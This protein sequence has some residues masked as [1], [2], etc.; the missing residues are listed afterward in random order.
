MPSLTHLCER[1]EYNLKTCGA[2]PPIDP[3]ENV[4]FACNK[5]QQH[6]A[7]EPKYLTEK[8]MSKPGKTY[9]TADSKNG[10]KIASAQ[11]P[12]RTG[13]IIP[14]K[15]VRDWNKRVEAKKLEKHKR[16]LEKQDA[17]RTDK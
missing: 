16:K 4:V 6:P 3:I 15:E 8:S 9:F 13:V 5:F 2:D 17:S 1:C 11:A 14:D 10:R 12:L 7:L